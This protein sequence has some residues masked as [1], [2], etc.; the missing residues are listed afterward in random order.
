VVYNPD[1]IAN[2]ISLTDAEKY[3][4]VRYDSAQ[5]KAFIV[6]KPDGTEHQF[7][8]M[9]SGLYYLDTVWQLHR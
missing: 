3:F 4:R 8:K 5:E 2:I 7:I 1:G 6:E 9:E